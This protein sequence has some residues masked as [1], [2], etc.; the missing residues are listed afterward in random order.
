MQITLG[1]N[2]VFIIPRLEIW[3]PIHSMVVV[4]SPIGVQA[5]PA[6]AA[7][8]I[9]PAK[10]RR[11]SLPG[12]SFRISDTITM[13]VVR[14]SNMAERKNVTQ[15][16]IQSKDFTFLVLIRSV[17]N[18]KPWWAS[19][20]STMVMAPMRNKSIS[21]IWAR[22]W[23]SSWPTNRTKRSCRVR[24][25]KFPPV[26]DFKRPTKSSK[27]GL[28]KTMSE[29]DDSINKVQQMTPV[30]IADADLFIL[31]PLSK[32]NWTRHNLRKKLLTARY[33]VVHTCS[34][35]DSGHWYRYP[36]SKRSRIYRHTLECFSAWES[37][38]LF[39]RS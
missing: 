33:E 29:G 35:L 7:T 21:E 19:I 36:Y 23:E 3:P 22:W 32:V 17:I 24:A 2:I 12:I 15:H 18:R 1:R 30:K 26:S 39:P 4:T 34:Y 6:F 14:L 13:A 16:I 9:I 31:V 11:V 8:T 20:S 5:P 38:G 28:F 10:K 27:E 37:Y 25:E